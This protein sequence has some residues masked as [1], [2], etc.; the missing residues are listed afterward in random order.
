MVKRSVNVSKREIPVSDYQGLRDFLSVLTQEES[1]AI[2][3]ETGTLPESVSGI[4][5]D[6]AA[7]AGSR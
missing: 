5:L 1:K 3:L 4:S 2:T 7:A 6:N